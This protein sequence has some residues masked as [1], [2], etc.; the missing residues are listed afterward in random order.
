MPAPGDTTYDRAWICR[1]V[2]KR[3]EERGLGPVELSEMC[4]VSSQRISQIT[5]ANSP[6]G[7]ETLWRLAAALGDE[8]EYAAL[9]DEQIRAAIERAIVAL[10]P[11]R[12]LYLTQLSSLEAQTMI[13][14]HESRRSRRARAKLLI[15]PPEPS[16]PT[17]K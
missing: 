5:A 2:A 12:L 4:G 7:I 15:P 10:G 14:L 9:P 3:M 16:D 1:W 8:E 6:P 13:D 17:K 11:G